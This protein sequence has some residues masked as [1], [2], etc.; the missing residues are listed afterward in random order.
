MATDTLQDGAELGLNC[1]II[2]IPPPP[3]PM[4]SA[5]NGNPC[6]AAGGATETPLLADDGIDG[7]TNERDC[8]GAD[9]VASPE[10]CLATALQSRKQRKL[11]ESKRGERDPNNVDM[12]LNDAKMV[13]TMEEGSRAFFR[14]LGG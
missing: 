12:S 3:P 4:I 13:K 5:E 1:A 9:S 7:E 6:Q 2:N 8:N 11:G 10:R 14:A